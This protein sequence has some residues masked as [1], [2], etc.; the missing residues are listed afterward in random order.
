[1]S[2]DF[3]ET[4]I[5]GLDSLLGGGIPSGRVVIVLGE[6]GA[7]K[8]TLCSLFLANGYTKYNESGVYVSLE[9]SRDHLFREMTRFGINF[10][11]AEKDLH[12][13]FVDASPIR[14]IPNVVKAGS[15]TIGKKEFS[16]VSVIDSIKRSIAT[17]NA[18]RV[19]VDPISYL[20]FQYSNPAELRGALLDL[21]EALNETKA[22]VLLASELRQ[23]GSL[24]RREIQ[25]E[26]YVGHG[27]MI[28][29]SI[30]VG[31]SLVRSIQVSKMRECEI[32]RQP[33]P[34]RITRD[35][36]EVFPKET[37]F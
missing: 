9:E 13:A 32:D 36:I 7:G 19:V 3:S 12:F 17:V 25:M 22:T 15:M 33:R 2:T 31:K 8:T 28:M 34:Y 6:P 26:E 11:Q 29:Q 30:P 10:A 4:G 37:V 23:S 14:H 5:P 24:V 20:I 1:M 21:V 16:L 18:K 35:G 27:T